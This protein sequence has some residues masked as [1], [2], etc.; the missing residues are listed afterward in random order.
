MKRILR[1]SLLA[2][3]VVAG[4]C[5]GAAV[6]TKPIERGRPELVASAPACAHVSRP[7]LSDA[8]AGQRGEALDLLVAGRAGEAAERL[9]RVLEAR[10]TDV[11]AYALRAAAQS[12][13]AREAERGNAAR[14]RAK[15]I[16]VPGEVAS[17]PRRFVAE[18]KP[19]LRV[20][21]STPELLDAPWFDHHGLP[22]PYHLDDAA[23]AATPIKDASPSRQMRFSDHGVLVFGESLVAVAPTSGSPVRL[24]D[25]HDVA[26]QGSSVLYAQV[27]SRVLVA[28]FSGD[29]G[30]ILVGIDLDQQ[31]MLWRTERA[32]VDSLSFAVSGGYAFLGTSTDGNAIVT[33]ELASGQIVDRVDVPFA[34]A[35][36]FA[37]DG[38]IVA[39][40]TTQSPSATLGAQSGKLA[41]ALASNLS[42]GAAA[43][44][45]DGALR[46]CQYGRAV[47]AIDARDVDR[48][49]AETQAFV[50]PDDPAARALAGA[51][52]FI[53]Q[54]KI[55]PE[56]TTDLAGAP[57]VVLER[58][59]KA[60]FRP[61]TPSTG[62]A[63][64]LKSRRPPPPTDKRPPV[65]R[66]GPKP[67]LP[68]PPSLEVDP[69]FEQAP[70]TESAPSPPFALP[71]AYGAASLGRALTF[72]RA[73]GAKPAAWNV[74]VYG[75]HFIAVLADARAVHMFDA[76]ALLAGDG[77]SVLDVAIVGDRL[78][79]AVGHEGPYD[80]IESYVAAYALDTGALV[81]RSE[82]EV[83]STSLLLVG[84]HVIV[85]HGRS[86]GAS[87]L[88]VLRSDTGEIV[89][90]TPASCRVLSIGWSGRDLL[91]TCA[92]GWELFEVER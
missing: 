28:L 64:I 2:A 49:L 1:T 70:S 13:L 11:A 20:V 79:V 9:T 65:V 88:V 24:F 12:A 92:E 90:T 50:A 6:A 19:T 15:P 33:V 32:S 86:S 67:L 71:D 87:R 58:P 21:D 44:P 41:P 80:D 40:D 62:K 81:W 29:D 69:P 68:A 36:I 51:A 66:P 35:W 42:E 74:G 76:S 10:P 16:H 85:G 23:T 38:Q 73:S 78:L 31:R 34:P 55:A 89:S 26:S 56:T 8:I 27:V 30:G 82:S 17:A 3:S 63:P 14:A 18:P 46:A 52:A 91:S 59:S 37:K 43:E 4:G 83:A 45:T 60:L 72:S 5:S 47:D 48:A 75:P 7:V 53:R 39:T 57:V 77:F 54:A 84:D 22:T 61:A 25:L